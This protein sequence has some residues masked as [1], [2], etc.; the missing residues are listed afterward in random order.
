MTSDEWTG[1][2]TL[3][4]HGWPG[5][6]TD[7]QRAAYRVLLD[8]LNA[9]QVVTALRTLVRGGGTFRPP[10]AEIA[11]AVRADPSQPT[12]PEA[13]RDLK[14]A[15]FVRQDYFATPKVKEEVCCEWLAERSHELVAAF[16]RAQT[17]ETLSTLPLEDP[18][19]DGTFTRKRLREDW[20][21][22]VERADGRVAQG[23][24]ID[25]GTARKQIG[26]RK[27]DFAGALPAGPEDES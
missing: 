10:A 3:L 1:I 14:R 13:Y 11:A 27:P 19:E 17:Y 4:E 21:R 2:C 6:F 12:W 15:L 26:P 25:A 23:L 8:G 18:D 9:E 16:F 7:G 20:E 24:P 22:F 5:E